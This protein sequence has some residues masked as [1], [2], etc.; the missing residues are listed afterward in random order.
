MLENRKKNRIK[1]KR[2][3]IETWRQINIVRH[4]ANERA[5]EREA[6]RKRKT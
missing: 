2:K 6:D 3:I 5:E 4:S 1:S